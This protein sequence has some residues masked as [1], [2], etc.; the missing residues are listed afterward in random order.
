M[1]RDDHIRAITK[2]LDVA[3]DADGERT[4]SVEL[5]PGAR[6]YSL[7]FSAARFQETGPSPRATMRFQD[8][9]LEL[10]E[11]AQIY[12]ADLPGL[13]WPAFAKLTVQPNTRATLQVIY[14]HCR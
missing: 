13:F 11:L 1:H 3:A 2:H 8:S 7:T 12:H 5:C 14:G 6:V 4:I 9:E 10:T